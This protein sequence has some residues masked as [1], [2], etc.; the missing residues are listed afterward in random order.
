MIKRRKCGRFFCFILFDRH[1]W[2][3]SNFFAWLLDI[4]IIVLSIQFSTDQFRV[5]IRVFWYDKTSIH[6]LRL[7]SIHTH[8]H[9]NT[10]DLL[11]RK[12]LSDKQEENPLLFQTWQ[13]ILKKRP[14]RINWL[15][16][17]NYTLNRMNLTW[18]IHIYIDI[19]STKANISKKDNLFTPD[20]TL[21]SKI[22]WS[23]AQNQIRNSLRLNDHCH[24][25]SK[26]HFC[27]HRF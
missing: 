21:F 5:F 17:L 15:S 12:T 23:K 22:V 9:M 6:I 24:K 16:L 27:L 11:K 10:I 26:Q 7:S 20:S 19:T 13:S 25:N 4:V 14:D 8:T 1:R 2:N 3:A 18:H